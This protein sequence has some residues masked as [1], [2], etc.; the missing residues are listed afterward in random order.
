MSKRD[1]FINSLKVDV[2][3]TVSTPTDDK[4]TSLPEEHD[5]P[6]RELENEVQTQISSD[7]IMQ[8][9]DNSAPQQSDIEEGEEYEE[10]TTEEE[11][12][13]EFEQEEDGEER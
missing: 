2:T 11:N 9:I 8:G 4:N 5:I 13:E 12:I 6:T 10:S 1:D 7:D 3:P